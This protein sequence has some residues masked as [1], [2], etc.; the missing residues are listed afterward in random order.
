MP[1]SLNFSVVIDKFRKK[2]YNK[3]DYNGLVRKKYA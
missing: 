1:L 2:V 3:N